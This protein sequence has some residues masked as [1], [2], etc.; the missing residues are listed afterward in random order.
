MNAII[1][2]IAVSS[3]VAVTVVNY[4]QL[5]QVQKKY[6]KRLDEVVND[7]NAAQKLEYDF[8]SGHQGR[9]MK[10]ETAV[11]GLKADAT[12]M[13]EEMK[14]VEEKTNVFGELLYQSVTNPTRLNV[15]VA[16]ND[17]LTAFGD[18]QVVAKGGSA[19]DWQAVFLNPNGD[20]SVEM[21]HGAG[22]GMRINTNN[23]D[24]NKSALEIVNGAKNLF[25]V[26][27]DGSS[28]VNGSFVADSM[29]IGDQDVAT[30]DW[31][32]FMS[33]PKWDNISGKPSSLVGP[34]GA[35]G[36]PGPRGLTGEMGPMGPVGPSGSTSWKTNDWIKSDDGVNRILNA[37]SGTTSFGSV[38]GYE[39]KNSL[40]KNIMT[41][42]D[43][44]LWAMTDES[45]VKKATVNT[46]GDAY[47]ANMNANK[48]CLGSRCADSTNFQAQG[49]MGPTGATGPT[50]P[51]GATGAMGATGPRGATGANGLNGV[52][53]SPGPIGAT[54]SPGTNGVTGPVGATGSPG[55]AGSIGPAGTPGSAGSPGPAGP[56]GPP[57]PIGP[58]GPPGPINDINGKL[59]VYTGNRFAVTANKMNNGSLTIGSL[60]QNYG[61]E[62]NTA[63]NWTG[64]NTAGLLMETADKTEIAI[65]DNGT[66][67][68][69]AM[70][71]DGPNNTITI[72]RDMGWGTTTLNVPKLRIGRWE[73]YDYNGI[74]HF[75]DTVSPG[76]NRYIMSPGVG[77]RNL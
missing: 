9:T 63:G 16:N 67:V 28:V 35:T 18:R 61:G 52:T 26:Y 57:G 33:K 4:V 68:A 47:F 41:L 32:N 6:D 71:Y 8:D 21:N 55:P 7:V 20:R 29:K 70:Y 12:K 69:S 46:S 13:T 40:D 76:D 50:G 25:N 11:S 54:G 66:R 19:D 45:G 62:F 44:G 17:P 1:S 43:T 34:P 31:V 37:A 73:I 42:E 51:T 53:G 14:R 58:I 60:D 22:M 24:G 65:H 30:Q 38:K 48:L 27:N 72:G 64:T 77:A 3:I 56:F 5:A 36:A 59:N 49:P 75:R 39:W 74:L 15:G 2:A 10:M 23:M